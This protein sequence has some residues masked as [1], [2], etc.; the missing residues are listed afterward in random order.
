V[1]LNV[2]ADTS[3]KSLQGLCASTSDWSNSSL[4]TVATTPTARRG[5]TSGTLAVRQ[6]ARGEYMY[7][8]MIDAGASVTRL[9]P[10]CR[11]FTL[12]APAR[13]RGLSGTANATIIVIA[14]DTSYGA[15]SYIVGRATSASGPFT[16]IGTTGTTVY[17][18]TSAV[19][20]TTYYYVVQA[21]NSLGTSTPSA[22]LS[23]RANRAPT[24]SI[25]SPASGATFAGPATVTINAN[26]NDTDGS[27]GN[28]EFYQGSNLLGSDASAPYSFGWTGVTG[29]SYSLTVKAYD[30]LGAVTTSSA[31]NITV[32]GASSPCSGLCTNPV[33]FTTSNYQSGNLGTATSC[34]Q[35]T[36]SLNGG[37]CSNIGSRTLS[38]NGTAMNCNGWALP[39]KRNGGYCIQVTSG[40]PDY[41]SFVT[42]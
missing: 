32:S 8:W 19:A 12:A 3:I 42:W 13:P 11:K 2:W 35:T 22:P 23:V 6:C 28:V 26:A 10:I 41:T 4:T 27:I 21:K 33:V 16:T 9:Q 39:V 24:V 34:R 17:G 29:G 15:S 14:W 7:G 30:N 18:D 5:G 37:N 20:G 31:V 40:T 36:A 1:G 25:T 38:V